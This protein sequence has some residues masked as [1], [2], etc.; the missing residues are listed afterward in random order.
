[1]PPSILITNI[2]F[3]ILYPSH[4]RFPVK[5]PKKERMNVQHSEPICHSAFLKAS[6]KTKN[7]M[8]NHFLHISSGHYPKKRNKQNKKKPFLKRLLTNQNNSSDIE[9]QLFNISNGNLE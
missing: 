5:C 8:A 7:V 4:G 9:V 2:S 3:F 1:M 6:F